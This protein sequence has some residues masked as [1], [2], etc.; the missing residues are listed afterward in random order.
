[1]LS[2]KYLFVAL[3]L[4]L[5]SVLAVASR[6]VSHAQNRR[7]TPVQSTPPSVTLEADTSTITICPGDSST[8]RVQLRANGR[9]PEGRE[10]RYV[11]RQPAVGRIEGEGATVTWDLTGA[12]PGVH[13]ATVEVRTGTLDD[14][15]TAFTSVP[16]VV[17]ACPPP[18]IICPNLVIYC[19]DTVAANSP[20][21]FTVEASGGS[22][23]VTPTYNWRISAGQIT[24]GQGTNSITVDTTGLG[25]KAITATVEVAGYERLNCTATCTT[26]VPAP[27]DASK[28]DLYPPIRFNDEKARLDNFAVQL[29]NEPTAK[30][31]I[32]VYGSRRGASD[33]ASR[34]AARARDYL[35]N[36]RSLNS[37]RIVILEGARQ[38]SFSTELWI[39]PVGATPPRPRM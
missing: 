25:G 37:D 29:Q 33:E 8:A 35:I 15:C 20:V 7:T 39:V 23:G 4:V 14:E 21:T 18:R 31:Y 9:S 30:G 22:P 34:R 28:F 12:T 3:A 17:A 5:V 38:E 1:M 11:W 6:Q 32:V 13:T 27:P 26:Q 19:P 36:E 16:V 10:L 2:R 24:G